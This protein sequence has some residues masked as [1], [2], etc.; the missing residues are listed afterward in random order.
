[1]RFVAFVA[2][3]GGCTHVDVRT[4]LDDVAMMPSNRPITGPY[5]LGTPAVAKRCDSGA[6]PAHIATAIAEIQGEH[7]AVV[8]VVVELR[9]A[10]AVTLDSRGRAFPGRA[11]PVG[12]L[13]FEVSGIPVDF[14][15]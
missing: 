13:C 9:P 11:S 12:S 14:V 5:T 3:L 10:W 15:E 4:P 7:D 2:L 6:S 8:Q 1:M